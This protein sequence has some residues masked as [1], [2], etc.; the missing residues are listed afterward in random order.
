[1]A[2]RNGLMVDASAELPQQTLLEPHLRLM[3]VRVL[4][5]GE[6]IVDQR[7]ST[8]THQFNQTRLNMK[9]AVSSRSLP[10]KSEEIANFMLRHVA[11]DFDHAFGLFP[12]RTHSPVFERA[13]DAASRVISLS[14]PVR[15]AVGLKGPLLSEC[16][17]SQS[18]FSGY[19]VQVQ[20]VL[21]MMSMARSQSTLRARLE[22]IIPRTVCYVA[23]ADWT[24][25]HARTKAKGESINGALGTLAARWLKLIPVVVIQRGQNSVVAKARTLA[26]AR[27][28]IFQRAAA[29][30]QTGLEAPYINLSFS[31]NLA[32]LEAMPGV[33]ALRELANQRSVE[34]SL[35]E[36]SPSNS[37]MLGSGALTLGFISQQ[38]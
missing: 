21:R 6:T 34:L 27:E 32:D 17:D 15:N 8:A 14:M 28:D 7:N 4:I 19:G 33:A 16:Y 23:P 3:P 12:A 24:Y 13:F 20:E 38:A 25:M 35:A 11:T 26:Q 30:L 9:G 10:L 18:L 36:M 22:H 31:G 2:L 29:A 37:V 1:M 5:N